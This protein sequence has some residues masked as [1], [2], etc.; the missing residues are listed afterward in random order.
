MND[1]CLF[2]HQ[3]STSSSL[4]LW[5]SSAMKTKH[6]SYFSQV[7]DIMLCKEIK[8]MPR[9]SSNFLT[10][11]FVFENYSKLNLWG[12]FCSLRLRRQKFGFSS[13]F[14]HAQKISKQQKSLNWTFGSKK[15][16]FVLK[17]S[18]KLTRGLKA[19]VEFHFMTTHMKAS[20]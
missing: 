7:N 15:L 2:K 3:P 18:H 5:T 9:H 20:E 4:F 12:T 6:F 13:R 8:F 1:V 14:L 10:H 11:D 16:L 19:L 17:W